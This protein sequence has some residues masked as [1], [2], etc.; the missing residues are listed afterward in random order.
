PAI[1][2]HTIAQSAREEMF[3]ASDSDQARRFME[4]LSSAMEPEM[5]FMGLL[6]MRSDF[7]GALQAA[8]SLTARF[9]EFSLAPMPL[10]RIPQIIEGP[11]R[12][13]GLGLDDE[14]VQAAARD[15][16]TEDA[17]PLLA[18][19]L[20]ELYDRAAGDNHLSLDEYRALGD[21]A[22]GLTPLEN[23]VRKSADDVLA[24]A[25]P[26][27]AEEAALRDAFVPQ[28]VRV[29]DQG[30]Y[31]RQPARW[32]E[33][34]AK[35]HPLLD[36]LAKARL[37]II[38]QEDDARNVEVA[39]EALLRKWP[40]LR[41]WLDEAR[42]FLSGKQQ[43]E[44]DL[45]DWTRAD[46]GVKRDALLTGLKLTRARGWI[47]ERPH[48]LSDAERAFISASIDAEEAEANRKARLRRIITVSSVAAAVILAIA[49]GFSIYQWQQT[50]QSIQTRAK[51]QIRFVWV[52]LGEKEV[53]ARR[54]TAFAQDYNIEPSEVLPNPIRTQ[55]DGFDCKTWLESGF[56]S[57]Y[58]SV[59]N[60]VG[61]KKLEALSGIPI[62]LEGS[63]HTDELNFTD[64]G[65]FGRY[66]PEFLA[67]VDKYLFPEDLD[68][69]HL[70]E[71]ARMVY[72]N[73]I[74]PVVRA[75]YNSHQILF[76]EPAAYAA[77]EQDF[78][79]TA[80]IYKM[81]G[82]NER[83]FGSEVFTLDEVI[84]DYQDELATGAV[85]QCCQDDLGERFRWLADYLATARDDDW[86]LANTAGGFWVRRT[87]DGTQG[88]IYQLLVKIIR[89]FD[90]ET[91]DL[92]DR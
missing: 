18:F 82:A 88:Q 61:F 58:C 2:H 44:R 41:G 47:S 65:N 30:E 10:T 84:A 29:N 42:E 68:G 49:T 33:L 3:G 69:P 64:T 50:Q 26:G 34:P 72:D 83:R 85:T 79:E 36:R 71:T 35:A 38:R 31:V 19:A 11:A 1:T 66:N 23:A 37:L 27:A 8:E 6:C 78:E 86:Y 53:D 74:G 62:F 4:I 67:W 92:K 24:D 87:I 90:P 32:D 60:I 59:R 15:A 12:V 76:A 77:F 91:L 73:K 28:M 21:S 9:D 52:D 17:L 81:S 5:P 40:R 14:F 80:G 56:R 25:A 13:A 51:E 20:R 57:L 7:L 63:P 89:R 43:L 70:A 22:L 46:A 16:E 75:L 48:Q 55:R 54:L 39:H 45:A